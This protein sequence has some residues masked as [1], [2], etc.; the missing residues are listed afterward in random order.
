MK[1]LSDP[2]LLPCTLDRLGLRVLFVRLGLADR[3]AAAFLDERSLQGRSDGAWLPLAAVCAARLDASPAPLFLWHIGHCGSTLLSR[4]LQHWPGLQVLREPLALRGLAEAEAERDSPVARWSPALQA[5]LCLRIPSLLARSLPSCERTLIKA[6]SSCNA[7][8]APVHAAHPAARAILL[9]V[10]LEVYLA[11]ML[12]S[13]AAMHDALNF[14]PQRLAFLRELGCPARLFELR[15]EEVVAMGWM[16]ERIRFAQLGA[17]EI[18]PRLFRL[19]FDDFLAEPT[20]SLGVVAAHLG[21]DPNFV[22]VALASEDPVRYAKLTSHPYNAADRQHDLAES[23]RRNAAAICSGKRW[24]ESECRRL[25][26]QL[27]A[28]VGSAVV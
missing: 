16:A 3:H 15:P 25:P 24:V 23:R 7:L 6:T 10:G 12:K 11:T 20:K 13:Q 1:P 27:A 21:L 5:E 28:A 26:G 18:S 22:S 2:E 19:D 14:A 8:I 4:L 9:D 17:I